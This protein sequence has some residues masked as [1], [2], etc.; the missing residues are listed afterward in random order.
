[1]STS[2]WVVAGVALLCALGFALAVWLAH[3]S[4]ARVIEALV[5]AIQANEA[6]TRASL[7]RLTALLD[8]QAYAVV[9]Q[10]ETPLQKKPR[11]TQIRQIT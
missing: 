7:D 10:S 1:M 4:L 5:R 9:K 11:R 6:T 3:R 8:T 2:H